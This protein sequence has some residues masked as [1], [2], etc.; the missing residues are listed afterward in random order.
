M[1]YLIIDQNVYKNLFIFS[2]QKLFEEIENNSIEFDFVTSRQRDSIDMK[3]YLFQSRK[4]HDNIVNHFEKRVEYLRRDVFTF[5]IISNF[6]LY[7][8][9]FNK[10]TLDFIESF[11]F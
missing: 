6:K 3:I 5:S 10:S 4:S 7:N 11:C 2:S 9:D 1:I 8:V